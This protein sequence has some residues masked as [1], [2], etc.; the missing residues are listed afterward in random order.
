VI[1]EIKMTDENDGTQ[2]ATI[3][4]D[5][6]SVAVGSIAVGG[7]TGDINIHAGDSSNLSRQQWE[8]NF[9]TRKDYQ[10]T[11]PQWPEG[12]DKRIELPGG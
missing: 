9:G 5:S 3:Q 7:S 2:K 8:A 11:C 10:K 4:A 1:G 12:T 6:K